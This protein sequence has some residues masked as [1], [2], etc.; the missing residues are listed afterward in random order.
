MIMEPHL[1]PCNGAG[2]GLSYLWNISV[3][4]VKVFFCRAG[5]FLWAT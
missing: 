5:S 4:V 2:L 1:Y 3:V